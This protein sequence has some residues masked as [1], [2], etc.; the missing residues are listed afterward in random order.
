[1]TQPV[2]PRSYVPQDQLYVWAMVNPAAPT[3][4]GEVS[5]SQLVADCATFTYTQDWWN[6]ALSEDMPIIQ[7]QIFSTGDRNT[8]PGAIDDAR[9]D[10]WG[11]RIIR[12]IDRPARL[13]ILEMLLFAGDDRF[14]ALGVSTSA[15]QYIPRYLGPYPQLKDLAQ[16][17]A[18][19][20]DVQT[21]A[22]ITAEIQRLIQPG[23]TLGGARPKALLQTDNGPCVIKFSELDDPV[24]TPLIEH[25]TITLAAQAGM[26]VADTAVL[27][28]PP[29]Y[30]KA[31]H[32]LTIERFDR[33][34]PYRV[35]CQS[36]HT[37]L[38]AAGLEQSYSNLA[39][40]LL[41][42]GHPDRQTAMRE[43]LFKRMVFNI[44]MDNTDDHE[45]NHSISLNLADGYYDLTPAYDV[46]P[47]LQNLGYQALV[48]GTAGS[49]SSLE[50]ALTQINEYGI[51]MPRAIELIR[52]VAA[53]VDRWAAHFTALGVSKSDMEL[54]AASIDRDALRSQ[55]QAFL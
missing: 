9:P 19:V 53:A 42:L 34:G 36:A 54:L 40:I 33:L 17:A 26:Y 6:F 22:P 5:L 52:Q 44:L 27:P 32:A 23:V 12:H 51:K 24:D 43:E 2:S 11:E 28:L 38:R 55:R 3:L 20:E 41:R 31:R 18:A 14:G 29:R 8:A 15:E 4:V 1:M 13:S 47:S 30:G 48:V 45:R 50:N 46:V 25:A 39:T 37:A 35:H 21:Q 16:L 7:G 10:R 49:E